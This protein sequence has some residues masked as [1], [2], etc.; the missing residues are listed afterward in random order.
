MKLNRSII[1]GLVLTGGASSRMGQDKSLLHYGHRTRPE[2]LRM[3]DVLQPYCAEIYAA[4]HPRKIQHAFFNPLPDYQALCG[5]M[6]GLVTA[7]RFR[8][9]VPWLLLPCDMPLL[10]ERVI[11]QLTKLRKKAHKLFVL[12]SQTESSSLCLVFGFHRLHRLFISLLSREGL[13]SGAPCK[14]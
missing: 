8:P 2:V 12:G 9:H 10:Q 13:V 1:H 4:C 3:R 11:E 7:F 14:G 5:P 6:G